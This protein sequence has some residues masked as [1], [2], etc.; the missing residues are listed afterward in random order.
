VITVPSARVRAERAKVTQQLAKRVRIPGFRK[1]KVPPERIEAKFALDIDQ[2]TRQQ[3]IDSAFREAVELKSLEPISEP[4]VAN[5][6]YDRDSELTF[7]VAFDI[8]PEVKLSRLGGFRIERPAVTVT[9]EDV[10]ARL[11]MVRQQQ[12]L[13]KPVE[14]KAS[15]GDTVEVDITPLDAS[16]GESETRN[17]R[18]VMGEGQA[19][20]DVEAAIGSLDPGMSGEFEVMFPED[21]PDES[22]RGTGQ[23]L[24]IELKQVM[25]QEL[26]DVD[27]DFARSVGDF[28]DLESLRQVIAE[29]LQRM[30]EHEVE[31]QIDQQIIEQLI[32]AN[33]FEVP[34]SMVDRYVDALVGQP[35]EGADPDLVAQTRDE[36]RP[37]AEWG[38]KRTLILQRVA[39]DQGFEV[40]RE[41]VQAKV[42]E[43]AK[44]AG[45]SVGE[46]RGRLAKS[47]ELRDIER[48]LSDEKV[49]EFLREQSEIEV[50]G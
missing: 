14:R 11:E 25:E 20:P 8:R 17:Y 47:G 1:G 22:Q 2:Q 15:A 31:L 37:A 46:V 41:E 9:D 43:I 50:G 28:E 33:P 26:P 10:E 32:G 49:Y 45:R 35:P 12:A 23:R 39:E 29:D 42:E 4:R 30:R 27:D 36:A 16:D 19:I 34:S 24:H 38:I 40:S 3:V 5:V 48:R 21:C 13:W 44:R 7:E 6:S 18:F